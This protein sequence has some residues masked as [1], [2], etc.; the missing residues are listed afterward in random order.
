LRGKDSVITFKIYSTSAAGGIEGISS[1][2]SVVFGSTAE[3]FL[4]F[5]T[6]TFG[7]GLDF[8]LFQS[9]LIF[10][11]HSSSLPL[12]NTDNSFSLWPF[13]TLA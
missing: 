12:H 9:F 10:F 13:G 3:A 6:A 2:I 1:S 7:S 5:G 4:F 11:Y 8:F